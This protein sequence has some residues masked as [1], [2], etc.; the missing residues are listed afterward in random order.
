MQ[1]INLTGVCTTRDGYVYT[2]YMYIQID[3]YAY[4]L[5]KFFYNNAANKKHQFKH[6]IPFGVV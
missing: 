4:T 2:L 1:V 5:E 3:I 6:R